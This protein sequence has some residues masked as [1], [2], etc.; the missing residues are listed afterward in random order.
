M[1][2]RAGRWVST[3][4]SIADST[5]LAFHL[6]Q[7][8]SPQISLSDILARWWESQGN[9]RAMQLWDNN[10]CAKPYTFVRVST[11]AEALGKRI[12]DIPEGMA[13]EWT[14][15]LTFSADMQ[16]DSFY[17]SVAA[18]GL[19]PE[20]MHIVTYGQ[21]SSFADLEQI[22]FSGKW[23]TTDGRELGI[24]RGA[25]DTGGTRHVKEEDSRTV[26]AYQWLRGLRSG[27]MFGTKGMSREIPGE[28]VKLSKVETDTQGRKIPAGLS[29]HLI[30]GDAFKRIVFWRLGEGWDE[31]PISFHA[32]T[33]MDYLKQLASEILEKDRNGREQWKRIGQNHY[34]DTLVGHHSLCFWQWKP[35]LAELAGR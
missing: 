7:W 1:A 25:L 2:M 27:V 16:M 24:W 26:Q 10:V 32:G 35:S 20:R 8:E 18:H 21:V 5:V 6:R 34:L 22:V 13:P 30:N 31:E 23:P 15:A 4:G 11:D 17:Y 3:T 19:A 14:R 33:G 28:L 12:V 29:L 9:P